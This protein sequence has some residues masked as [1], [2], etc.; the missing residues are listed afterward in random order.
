MSLH[1]PVLPD[2]ASET[3]RC[4]KCGQATAAVG[5]LDS[6]T[7]ECRCQDPEC[8][9]RHEFSREAADRL[10]YVASQPDGPVHLDTSLPLSEFLAVDL[11]PRRWIVE[12]LLQ[13]RDTAMLHSFRGI[14]KSRFAQ[15]LACGVTAGGEFLRYLCPEPRGALLVD[16]ELPAAELQ[17]MLLTQVS[18]W[19]G[20]PVAPFKI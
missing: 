11:P 4:T 2:G 5:A 20:E 19:A 8:G 10:R 1:G 18:G 15:G 17:K 13:E 6:E 12:G 9:H 14:G 7:L 16:G 3:C